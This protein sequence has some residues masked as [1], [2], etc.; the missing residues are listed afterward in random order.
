MDGKKYPSMNIFYEWGRT[1]PEQLSKVADALDTK[2]IGIFATA[3]LII[4]VTAALAK[5]ICLNVSSIPFAVA[6][7]CFAIILIRSLLVLRGRRFFVANDPH[8]LK[9]DYWVLQP[10][11]AREEYWNYIEQNFDVNYS[12]VHVKGQVLQ[13]I[14][15]L[16]GVEVI[17]LIV[18]LLLT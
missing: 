3:C 10:N 18:W 13:W 1:A 11:E 17:S 2:I 8:I 12:L 14:V 4:S 7:V 5:Q 9:E 16:L 6:L 15:P